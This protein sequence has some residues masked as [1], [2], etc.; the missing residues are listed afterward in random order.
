MCSSCSMP[1]FLRKFFSVFLFSREKRHRFVNAWGKTRNGGKNNR[2]IVIRRDGREDI[3]PPWRVIPGVRVIFSGDNNILRLYQP[4]SFYDC[5]ILLEDGSLAE[6]GP[7]PYRIGKASFCVQNA[8]I[9]R[10]GKNF[11]CMDHLQITGF[12][13]PGLK[14]VI[15]DA[16]MFSYDVTMRPSD[17]HA[18][19]DLQT[20]KVLNQGKDIVLGK[21]VWV[22]MKCIFLK[23]AEIADNCVVGGGSLVN[24]SFSEPNS[25]YAGVPARRIGKR[26]VCWSRRNPAE[27][28]KEKL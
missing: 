21:H 14:V 5:D 24:K 9:L 26:P 2:I 11:S 4:F 8:G 3:L 22:G 12:D 1:R 17:G 18:V 7:S 28:Q 6:I 25:I 23:G 13:E 15:G 20:K 27:F 19:Y 16:C 10:I